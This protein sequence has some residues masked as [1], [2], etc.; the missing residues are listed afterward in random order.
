V[1]DCK[2]TIDKTYLLSYSQSVKYVDWNVVKNE[3]LKTERGIS[4]EDA[5]NSVI[6][7]GLLDV[8]EHPN[9]QKYSQQKMMVVNINDYVYLVPFVEDGEKIFLKTII[10]SRKAT[11]HYLIDPKK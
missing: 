9:P 6:D 1:V 5:I 3:L 4:F 11:K 8:M 10:P 7:G 2:L